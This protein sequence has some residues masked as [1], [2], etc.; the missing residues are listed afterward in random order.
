MLNLDYHWYLCQQYLIKS[1]SDIWC[2][3]STF[4]EE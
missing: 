2:T 3:G 4:V 1:F